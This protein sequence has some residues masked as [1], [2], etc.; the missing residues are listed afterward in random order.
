MMVTT[1]ASVF[2]FEHIYLFF[3]KK[4]LLQSKYVYIYIYICIRTLPQTKT[5]KQIGEMFKMIA[6]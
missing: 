4:T 6:I 5:L 1:I 3:Q 2:R